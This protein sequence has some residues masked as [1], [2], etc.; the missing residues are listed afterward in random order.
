MWMCYPLY[1]SPRSPPATCRRL[2]VL[3]C[4][5]RRYLFRNGNGVLSR[6]GN[7]GCGVYVR[8]CILWAYGSI[9]AFCE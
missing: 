6:Y 8:D 1:P 3:Y 7:A 2:Y 5:S 4:R 9:L